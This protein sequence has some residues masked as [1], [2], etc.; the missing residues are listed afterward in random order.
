M[1]IEGKGSGNKWQSCEVEVRLCA[2]PFGCCL[3]NTRD[4]YI[5]VCESL[6]TQK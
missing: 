6:A 4:P 1:T 5:A 3:A 2:G